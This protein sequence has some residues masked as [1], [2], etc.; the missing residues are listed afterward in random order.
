MTEQPS[1]PLN[2]GRHIPQIGYGVYQVPAED[3]AALVGSA[4]AAGYRHVDT[5]AFYQNEA[6]VGEAVR[7][8]RETIFVTTKLWNGDQGYD[9]TLR[10][11]DASMAALGLDW[12]DLYLIHWPVPRQNLYVESW[13]ALIRLR[14]EGRIRSIGVSNFTMEHLERIVHDT[15]VVP[16]VNQIEL[17]PRFQ[18]IELRAFH[19]ENKI[20]T[21]SWSP[22][23]QG[24]VLQDPV[25]ARIAAAH[26][27]TPAQVIIRW[28]IDN[29]LSVI[30]KSSSA[31][32]QAE[33]LD[34]FG[35]SL[36]PDDMA[37]IATLDRSDGRI[38]PDPEL[39]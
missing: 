19:D 15:G 11:F 18:Q 36:T 3:T 21:T 25:I 9:Q 33:N 13:K 24:A 16:A 20:V 5:A 28:H 23:G 6:G 39:L 29:G 4:I 10:A 35:F 8:T 30:P 26:G 12:L 38:G 34:V 27:R 1:L 14:E 32:R 37:A 22:L 7:A 2:D 31:E 17:H